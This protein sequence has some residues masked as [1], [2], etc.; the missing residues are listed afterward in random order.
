MII[1]FILKNQ[2]GLTLLELMIALALTAV[3]ISSAL[4]FFGTG[5]GVNSTEIIRAENQTNIRFAMTY[6]TK[7]LRS[8][9]SI[10]VNTVTD[11]IMITRGTDAKTYEL[12]NH[13]LFVIDGGTE[14]ELILDVERFDVAFD[15]GRK[16]LSITIRSNSDDRVDVEQTIDLYLENVTEQ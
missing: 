9:D 1:R 12:K 14:N 4:L 8:A 7:E 3:I 6:L 11:K 5:I 13:I 16:V 2:K 15:A 10:Q